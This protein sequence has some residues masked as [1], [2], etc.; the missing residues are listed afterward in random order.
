VNK[1]KVCELNTTEGN[2]EEANR[3]LQVEWQSKIPLERDCI[4][5]GAELLAIHHRLLV[6]K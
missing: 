5:S 1:C 2:G 3:G 4:G 6:V